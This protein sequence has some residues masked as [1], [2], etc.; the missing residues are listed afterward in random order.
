MSKHD[1]GHTLAGWIGFGIA[2]AG[3]VGIGLG[4]APTTPSGSGAAWRS[5]P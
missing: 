2:T 3:V 5:W 1:E 4:S